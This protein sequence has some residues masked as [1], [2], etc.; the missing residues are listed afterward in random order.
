MPGCFKNPIRWTGFLLLL[1]LVGGSVAS[2]SLAALRKAPYLV[3]PGDPTT[4]QVLWQATVTGPCTI[5]WGTDTSYILGS[6]ETAEYG[7]DHQHTYTLTDL[8]PD[9]MHFYRVVF[10][11]MPYTGSFRTAPAPGATRVKFFAYGDTRT[12]ASIHDMIAGQMLHALTIDA[13]RRSVVISVGDLVSSGDVETVWDSEFFSSSYPNIRQMMSVLPYQ[14]CMGNHEDAGILFTKYFPYPFIGNRYWSFD[15]GPAHFVVVDQYVSYAPG[16]A[17]YTWIRNDLATTTQPWRFVVLHEPG[18]SA[19]GGHSN[20]VPVQQYLQPLFVQYGVSLVFGGHNHYYARAVVDGVQHLTIGGGGAPL[21]T[22]VPDAPNIVASA[23]SHHY[24]RITIEG[25]HLG[26][27]AVNGTTVLD[28]FSL[29]NPSGVDQPRMPGPLVLHDPSPNPFNPRTTIR[30][31]LPSDGEVRL[32][33]FDVSGS[34]IRKL[35]D[36]NLPAGEHEAVWDGCDSA[37]RSMASGSY[38]ARLESG[39]QGQTK[40]MSLVR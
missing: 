22:P 18:W 30:F 38:F 26:F 29:A 25:D 32:S 33:I 19:G 20:E 34:L 17:Q 7:N 14:S 8:A 12:N 5:D 36:G 37:G 6:A 35:V 39:G 10:D 21:Y 2:P 31:D 13:E 3:F 11:G 4:M 27:A 16:S 23:R 28:T 9:Q 40:W 24:C 1:I 15:Y